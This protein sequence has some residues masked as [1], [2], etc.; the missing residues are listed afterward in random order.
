MP[1]KAH[2][3]LLDEGDF[4]LGAHLLGGGVA[5]GLVELRLGELLNGVEVAPLL[6]ILPLFAGL[7]LPGGVTRL[8]TRTILAVTIGV[9]TAK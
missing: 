2:L 9:L 3:V 6:V 8:V 1:S 4:V 7:S 5:H